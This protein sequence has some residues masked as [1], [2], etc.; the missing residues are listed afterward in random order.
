MHLLYYLLNRMCH[1]NLN[2]VLKKL[3]FENRKWKKMKK[4]LIPK[5]VFSSKI[6]VK[7]KSDSFFD[8]KWV[9]RFTN[10]SLMIKKFKN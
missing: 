6:L 7:N 3:A 8:E 4:K 10:F 1:D 9:V 5:Y 2:K